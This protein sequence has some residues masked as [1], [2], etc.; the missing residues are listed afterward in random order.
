MSKPTQPMLYVLDQIGESTTTGFGYNN[1]PTR[2]R[3]LNSNTV[4]ALIKR[5]LLEQ[6]GETVWWN[7]HDVPLYRLSE[8]GKQAL[9]DNQVPAMP[10][11]E[12]W[13]QV[14]TRG[15]KWA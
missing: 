14:F 9:K 15:E 4:H 2:K 12:A 1:N 3:Y 7:D 11:D 10:K 5:R 8:T 13:K 6:S